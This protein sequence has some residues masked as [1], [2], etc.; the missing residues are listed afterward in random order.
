MIYLPDKNLYIGDRVATWM[1]YLSEVA[2]GGRTV[3]PRVGAGVR[4]E[5][6]SAVFWHNLLRDGR[7]DRLTLHGAC[8][9]LLG[10]KWGRLMPVQYQGTTHI[11]DVKCWTL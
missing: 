11:R 7:A 9:V 2:E 5:A 6:G 8:P 1:F 3:F 4:P 10:T